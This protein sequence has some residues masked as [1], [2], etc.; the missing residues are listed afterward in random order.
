[1]K[2]Q[3]CLF[4]WLIAILCFSINLNAQIDLELE[5]TQSIDAADQ[6]SA[7]NVE[8]KIKNTGSETATGVSVDLK[9]PEGVVY[10]GGNEFTISQGFL[11]VFSQ[12]R[13]D[14]GTLNAGAEALAIVNYYQLVE[15][16]PVAY[17]QVTKSNEED[18]DST[19]N[20]GTPPIPNEDDEA[21]TNQTVI[22]IDLLP[23][24]GC[25][26][27]NSIQDIPYF[28]A[29]SL[30]VKF[31]EDVPF[32]SIEPFGG[33]DYT[34]IALSNIAVQ[35]NR[36]YRIRV[37][38][39]GELV[40]SDLL[41]TIP[42]GSTPMTKNSWFDYNTTQVGSILNLK[43]KYF[44]QNII[45]DK[46]IT[47]DGVS[48]IKVDNV[49]QGENDNIII[50]GTVFKIN[51]PETEYFPFVIVLDPSG[52]EINKKVFEDSYSQVSFINE[53]SSSDSYYFSINYCCSY[54]RTAL[55]TD[56]EF[57]ELYRQDFSNAGPIN[58][59]IT[60]EDEFGNVYVLQRNDFLQA[61]TSISYI[62]QLN[63]LGEEQ[64]SLPIGETNLLGNVI[65][66]EDGIMI[67]SSTTGGTKLRKIASSGE[68]ILE[69]I[70]SGSW[71]ALFNEAA[72][73]G[74]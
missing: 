10:V 74:H 29:S 42:S 48:S 24:V 55:K 37:S 59:K 50:S 15:D 51:I 8:I 32:V 36:I 45:W 73:G 6:W 68:I 3:K 53:S 25:Y 28:G 67:A 4:A 1:M 5:M 38:S 20:N 46:D 63:N 34:V 70:I 23:E 57:E 71:M 18:V 19:P 66:Q 69:E 43:R 40:S 27:E 12:E 33:I 7:Y 49:V 58:I 39:T 60:P 65:F 56:L 22:P 64:W 2:I 72:D 14:V 17:A 35:E 52:N 54:V 44:S 62:K 16:T 13:W 30:R 31:T 61:S 9:A 47:L 21:S 26:F 11:E 41:G